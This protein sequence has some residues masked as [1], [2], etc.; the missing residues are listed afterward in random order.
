M[1]QQ[2]IELGEILGDATGT[3]EKLN[4]N[5]TELYGSALTPEVA[6]DVVLGGWGNYSDLGTATTPLSYTGGSGTIKIPNDGLGAF[7]S[8]ASLPTGVSS[9]YN[10]T[11]QQIDLSDLNIGDIFTI[12]FDI[13]VTTSANSQEVDTSIKFGIGSASEFSVTV[14]H[15]SK[16]LTGDIPIFRQVSF[17]IF[18]ADIRDNPAELM[19]ESAN[20]CT[21]LVN[22]YFIPVS[23]IGLP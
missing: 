18:S 2:F 23:I 4:D 16:K 19:I 9:V 11:N 15:S 5:F 22:G 14:D 20:N 13:V 6:G 12:R 17:A 10:I 21:V 1:A 7:T 8:E 3:K